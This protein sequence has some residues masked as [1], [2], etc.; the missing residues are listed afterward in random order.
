M[1]TPPAPLRVRVLFPG[2]ERHA[3]AA[4]RLHPR[5]GRPG[6]TD[7]HIGG[8]LLWPAGEP[9]PTCTADHHGPRGPSA[10]DL[11]GVGR[12]GDGDGVRTAGPRVRPATE[13][14]ALVGLAQL[15]AA[16]VPGLPRP[17]EADLLQ[18]LW[19]PA[20]HDL[21]AFTGPVVHL[22]RR[23]AADVGPVLTAPPLPHTADERYLPRPCVL[24]PERVVEYPWY[25]QLP[26]E[27]AERVRLFDDEGTVDGHPLAEH[28]AEITYT[29]H[30]SVAPGWKVGGW[31]CWP[32]T[33]PM[34]M[35]C[36][37]CR[38]D[39][40]LLLTIASTEWK[41]SDAL[42]WRPVEHRR[43]AGAD[44]APVGTE[45]GPGEPT[46]VQVGRYG[47]LHV[48]TCPACPGSPPLLSL[49]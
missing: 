47:R 25:E 30:L 36:P 13:P 44:G 24:H 48:F 6:P 5:P 35:R 26:P 4:V 45:A 2:I 29:E 18:V 46:G 31:A 9:W 41:A 19:C 11:A 12:D 34:A 14:N 39:C 27:L 22:R 20:D 7:S 49:Q 1:T 23:R 16:H 3:R 17:A 28:L 15:Y 37:S 33:G 43:Q 38:C 21:G 32:L 8:P 42:R 10:S 40:D